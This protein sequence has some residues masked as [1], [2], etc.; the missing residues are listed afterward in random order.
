MWAGISFTTLRP[1]LFP[2]FGEKSRRDQFVT[3]RGCLYGK[4]PSTAI[5]EVLTHAY[6]CRVLGKPQKS[7]TTMSQKL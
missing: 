1:D 6:E 3:V 2:N 5:C 7:I 4:I